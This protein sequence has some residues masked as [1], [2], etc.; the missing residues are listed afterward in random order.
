MNLFMTELF[1][2]PLLQVSNFHD[3]TGVV[4]K[5]LGTDIVH[6]HLDNAGVGFTF[7]KDYAGCD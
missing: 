5:R 4:P 1:S 2:T 7:S 3:P 6:L